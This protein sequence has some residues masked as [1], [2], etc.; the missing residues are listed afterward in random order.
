MRDYISKIVNLYLFLKHNPWIVIAH[1][2]LGSFSIGEARE[3]GL[4]RILDAGSSHFLMV[5]FR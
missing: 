4:G 5:C 3:R 2:K 1:P